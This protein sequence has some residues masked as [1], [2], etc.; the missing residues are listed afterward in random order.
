MQFVNMVIRQALV[1]ILNIHALR[2]FAIFS[3]K[4][5]VSFI[6]FYVFIQ[7]MF[8]ITIYVK[9]CFTFGILKIH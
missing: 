9:K 8:Y 1:K 7:E 5:I 2:D 3:V 6:A 4:I